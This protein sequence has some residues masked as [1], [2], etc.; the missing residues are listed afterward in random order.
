MNKT[1]ATGKVAVS[2]KIIRKN[3]SVEEISDIEKLDVKVRSDENGSANN[4]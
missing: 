1:E 3:G 2:I 4:E